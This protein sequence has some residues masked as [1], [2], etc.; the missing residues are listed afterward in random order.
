MMNIHE[1]AAACPR[2]NVALEPRRR[3]GQPGPDGKLP[4][5]GGW[6]WVA[7]PKDDFRK[8]GWRLVATTGEDLVHQVWEREAAAEAEGD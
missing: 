8:D 4:W 1:V 5:T 7:R 3:L 6:W 2:W